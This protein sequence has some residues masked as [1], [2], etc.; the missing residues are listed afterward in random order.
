MDKTYKIEITTKT[1]IKLFVLVG[2]A[3]LLVRLTEIIFIIFIAFSVSAMLSPIVDFLHSKKVPRALSISLIYFLF[4]SALIILLLLSY[5]PI[6]TQMEIFIGEFP[7]IITNFADWLIE[8][9]PLIRDRFN[10]DEIFG[11]VKDNFLQN[12]Q[13]SSLS[14][15]FF[16]GVKQAFGIVGSIFGGLV[17]IISVFVLSIYF[18]QFK[19]PSKQKVLKLL[20]R[21]HQKRISNFI[22]AL[23][24]N[25]G[26][27]LR[28]QVLLMTLVGVLAWFGLQIIGA[29]FSIPLGIS[30]AFLEAVPGIGPT[31]SLIFALT[32]SI[33]SHYPLWKIIFIAVWFVLIQLFENYLI[34]PKLMQK[35][36]G[37]N[38]ML[39]LVAILGASKIMGLW[40]ALLAV[41]I[42]AIAQISFTHY[43]KYRKDNNK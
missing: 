4:F 32:V 31:I 36:V 29:E 5:K 12:F 28:A 38:P 30:A 26:A 3:W 9:I 15:Y 13:V 39:T 41:P 8:K 27:W 20:P 43:M 35:V 23:E 2:L 19:E 16:T 22:N 6:V 40:G 37:V 17:N 21:K 10:W 34:V 11:N 14:D 33:G 18:I 42:V 1:L 25:L 24:S 7:T